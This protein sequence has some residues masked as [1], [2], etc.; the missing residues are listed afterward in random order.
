MSASVTADSD[1]GGSSQPAI[2]AEQLCR[3]STDQD[4]QSSSPA[5]YATKSNSSCVLTAACTHAVRQ[6]T[7]A[8]T[9]GDICAS[10]TTPARWRASSSRAVAGGATLLTP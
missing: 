6:A 4:L 3:A 5:A 9:A 2:A 10:R 8:M 7:V 1:R